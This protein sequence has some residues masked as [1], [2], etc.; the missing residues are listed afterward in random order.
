MN[1]DRTGPT[2]AAL[3]RAAE[4]GAFAAQVWRGIPTRTGG[5]WDCPGCAVCHEHDD[6]HALEAF[7]RNA[8]DAIHYA[9]VALA[10]RD[11]EAC[12]SWQAKYEALELA[13]WEQQQRFADVLAG[14][15]TS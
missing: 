6:G 13:V 15:P 14:R 7:E 11:H 2:T 10:E 12:V 4:D 1:D 5:F 9:C 3:A 8:L